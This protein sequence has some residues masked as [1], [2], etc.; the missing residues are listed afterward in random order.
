[1]NRMRNNTRHI[2]TPTWACLR[3]AA[4]QAQR[5]NGDTAYATDFTGAG[6]M[7]YSAAALLVFDC[8]FNSQTAPCTFAV[9]ADMVNDC[10]IST[11]PLVRLARPVRRVE[12]RTGLAGRQMHRG[13]L[14]DRAGQ[15]PGRRGARDAQDVRPLAPPIR[16]NA[17]RSLPCPVTV[18]EEEMAPMPQTASLFL[19]AGLALATLTAPARAQTP[20]TVTTDTG[21]LAGKTSDGVTAYKGIPYAQAP[22]GPL[23]WRAPQPVVPWNGVR[24][25]TAFAADCA[26]HPQGDRGVRR[27]ARSPAAPAR[28]A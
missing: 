2:S 17:L 20:A 28:T 25:A 9:R 3:P 13:E 19:S 22:V 21:A 10:V 12:V 23:R 7:L 14:P 24:Q 8:Q 4:L 15:R 18:L 11:T 16:H 27:W 5:A 1:M 6:N 26:Q